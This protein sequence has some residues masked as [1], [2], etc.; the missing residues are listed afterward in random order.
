LGKKIRPQ[1]KAFGG[2]RHER[3]TGLDERVNNKEKIFTMAK[4]RR[5]Q[6]TR[7]ERG[8]KAEIHE[9]EEG[10]RRRKKTAASEKKK[11][12]G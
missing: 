9:L 1:N 11:G 5:G 4:I 8:R 10:P 2:S 7:D 12:T 3:Q 6:E